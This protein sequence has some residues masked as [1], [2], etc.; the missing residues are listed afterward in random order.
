MFVVQPIVLMLRGFKINNL[1]TI[2]FENFPIQFCVSVSYHFFIKFSKS[3]LNF[4]TTQHIKSAKLLH[5]A[6]NR[7]CNED[8]GFQET[9]E[10]LHLRKIRHKYQIFYV[11]PIKN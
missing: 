8:Q 9:A 3:A 1:K 11:C 5:P 7:I 4:L 6:G 10:R 2:N